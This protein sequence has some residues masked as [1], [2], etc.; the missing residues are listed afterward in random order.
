MK[1]SMIDFKVLGPNSKPYFDLSKELKPEFKKNGTIIN[2]PIMFSEPV[3]T[4]VFITIGIGVAIHLINKL[5]DK[6]ISIF[7]K[8]ITFQGNSLQ[9]ERSIFKFAYDFPL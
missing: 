2:T 7:E 5:I 3:I 8:E 1:Y 6:L 9:C 4:T